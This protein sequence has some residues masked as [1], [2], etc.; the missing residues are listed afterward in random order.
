MDELLFAEQSLWTGLSAAD[1]R[2]KLTE[3]ATRIGLDEARFAADLD[4]GA[5]TAKVRAACCRACSPSPGG[6]S[7]AAASRA[8][9]SPRWCPPPGV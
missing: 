9:R 2:L 8:T 3:Y 1:F 5:F 6:G 7:A 4:G